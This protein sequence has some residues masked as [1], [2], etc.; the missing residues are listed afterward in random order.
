MH[1]ASATAQTPVNCSELHQQP[2]DAINRPTFVQKCYCKL[3]SV[4]TFTFVQIFD[5]DLTTLL[6]G[7]KVG[8]LV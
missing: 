3:P 6:N 8:A 5:R 4:A 7:V 2:V 1:T